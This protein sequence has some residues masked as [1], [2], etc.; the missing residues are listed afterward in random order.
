MLSPKGYLEWLDKEIEAHYW[1]E[2]NN[3][4][5]NPMLWRGMKMAL[6]EAKEKFLLVHN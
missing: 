2:C 6:I 1:A 3:I 4:S 5:D